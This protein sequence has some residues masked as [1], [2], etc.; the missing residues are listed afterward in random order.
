LL[1]LPDRPRWRLGKL[2]K[3]VSEIGTLFS[4]TT[5]GFSAL[6]G[7]IRLVSGAAGFAGMATSA[8]G[9][10]AAV[11]GSGGLL[12]A[13][14]PL[15]LGLGA[16]AL[17]A[18][19]TYLAY[20]HFNDLGKESAHDFDATINPKIREF[21]NLAKDL[22]VTLQGTSSKVD[23]L[24]LAQTTQANAA[25]MVK[26][27]QDK[28]KTSQDAY[29]QTQDELTTKTN[30]YKDAQQHAKDM[31]DQFGQNSPQY[32]T[33]AS[34]LSDAYYDLAQKLNQ[35]AGNA[36]QVQIQGGLLKD[37]QNIWKGSTYDLAN[38]QDYLNRM[39]QGGIGVIAQFGPTASQQIT[40][41][42]TLQQHIAGV[43]TSFNNMSIDIQRQSPILNASLQGIGSTIGRVQGQSDSLNNSLSAAR[44]SVGILQG[45]STGLQGSGGGLQG[46]RHNAT[47]TNNFIGGATL[48]GEEGPELAIFPRGTMIKTAPQTR[49][50]MSGANN[51]GGNNGGSTGGGAV[52]N[53]YVRS[54]LKTLTCL[55]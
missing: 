45:A 13:L 36:L 49:S 28:L 5:K 52:V 17:V 20:K 40:A 38:T 23:L 4:L 27:A 7:G 9:A 16:V 39:L 41:I 2:G 22:G 11:A 3:T 54:R 21:H 26:V 55:V 15:A 19:G 6:S 48:V 42:D 31:L 37:A 30:A 14:G 12:A 1:W 46:G 33:A 47:G 24:T 43:V 29:K 32:Q 34:Q 35:T 10:T 50:L 44:S 53:H 51:G 18:G 25:T 8:E